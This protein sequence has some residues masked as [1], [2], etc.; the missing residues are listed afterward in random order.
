MVVP[1]KATAGLHH[2]LPGEFPLTY[3]PGAVKNPMHGFLNLFAAA[4]LCRLGRLNHEEGEN[5]L[6]SATP[7]AIDPTTGDFSFQ[8]HRIAE[9]EIGIVRRDFARSF[10]SCSFEEP[11]E[12][13]LR[14][15]ILKADVAR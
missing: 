11:I 12:D 2:P 3:E 14:L 6:N 13:L 9:A 5:L 7:P 4:S 1:F 15:G 8:D 10:G